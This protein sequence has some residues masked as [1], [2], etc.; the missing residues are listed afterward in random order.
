M[1]VDVLG[2]AKARR[3]WPRPQLETGPAVALFAGLGVG[4]GLRSAPP[5]RHFSCF[6]QLV[7][8]TLILSP[9]GK[10]APVGVTVDPRSCYRQTPAE[11]GNGLITL[12]SKTTRATL[13]LARLGL[14]FALHTYDYDSNADRIGLQAAEALGVEPRRRLK[15]LMAEVDG[16]PVCVVVPSD[17]EVSMKKLAAAFAGKAANMMRPADAERLTGYILRRRHQPVRTE[18]ARAGGD[19]PGGAE[20]DQRVSDWWAAR[21]ADR[22]RSQRRRQGARCDR[23]AADGR[24]LNAPPEPQC[25][26]SGAELRFMAGVSETMRVREELERKG[27][28]WNC[29]QQRGA[30]EQCGRR[31]SPN[32]LQVADSQRPNSH[33]GIEASIEHAESERAIARGEHFRQKRKDGPRQ[34]TDKNSEYQ[35]G[36][37][38]MDLR[39]EQRKCGGSDQRADGNGGDRPARAVNEISARWNGHDREPDGEACQRR[40]G[41]R[42]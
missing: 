23:A 24:A 26:R 12:M 40:G 10:T 28:G 7:W 6:G 1:S 3:G 38:R 2:I 39:D 17:R 35:A 31:R 4:G 18:K 25:S 13:A 19:R 29:D 22:A 42:R 41:G 16:K 20:R 37:C 15:T 14:K 30:R 36:D 33:Q 8:A 9:Q 32:V 27:Q 11:R 21:I 5:I 34:R